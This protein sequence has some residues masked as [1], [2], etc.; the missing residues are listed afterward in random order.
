[1]EL[2]TFCQS[3]S[4]PNRPAGALDDSAEAQ[5]SGFG[6]PDAA[7]RKESVRSQRIRD[8]KSVPSFP[9][10][11][12]LAFRASANRTRPF[13]SWEKSEK[14]SSYSVLNLPINEEKPT[15]RFFG[16]VG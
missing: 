4:E 13:S 16:T 12:G 5:P 6:A 9:N 1:L 2:S 14:F 7:L 11:R 8:R 10:S 3:A 15:P